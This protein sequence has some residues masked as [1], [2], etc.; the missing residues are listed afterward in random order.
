MW[1]WIKANLSQIARFLAVAGVLALTVTSRAADAPSLRTLAKGGF[2]GITEARLSVIRDQ[3]SWEQFWKEH[4][5][6][7]TNPPPAPAVDFKKEM[8]LTATLGRRTTGG[9][10][11]E[12]T[13]IQDDPAG[14]KVFVV[15]KSPRPGGMNLQSLT[16]PFHFV[17]VPVSE[18][19]V[20][21]VDG[22]NSPAPK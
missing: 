13:R 12:F 1:N 7:V 17:A 19:K 20:E 18:K 6:R 14:L 5:V 15:K 9:F 22:D 10:S 3:A 4:S 11:I 8:V 2:S 21:F 16:A